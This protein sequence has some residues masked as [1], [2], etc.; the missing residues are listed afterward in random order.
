M[1]TP[2][3]EQIND[4]Q[5]KNGQAFFQMLTDVSQFLNGELR[6]RIKNNYDPNTDKEADLRM[7]TEH[8]QSF[9][10][11]CTDIEEFLREYVTF[12]SLEDFRKACDD[13]SSS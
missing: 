5:L 4:E 6:W 8:F 10:Q 2:T 3:D 7:T 11:M 13:A 12:D 9:M 1:T